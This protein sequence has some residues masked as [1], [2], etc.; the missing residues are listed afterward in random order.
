MYDGS[1]IDCIAKGFIWTYGV[2]FGLS[3]FTIPLAWKDASSIVLYGRATLSDIRLSVLAVVFAAIV[4]SIIAFFVSQK[5]L[6]KW[7]PRFRLP[8]SIDQSN[9]G[10]LIW[11]LLLSHQ[12]FEFRPDLFNVYSIGQFFDPVGYVA[13]GGFFVLWRR[14]KLA[15]LEILLILCIFLPIEIYLRLKLQI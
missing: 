8:N 2:F 9:I 12:I 4:V 3:V 11:P 1:A 14:N 13:F 10:I 5:Y 15:R 6:L 7:L